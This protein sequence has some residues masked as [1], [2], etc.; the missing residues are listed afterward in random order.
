MKVIPLDF[1]GG[2]ADGGSPEITCEVRRSRRKTLAV[3]VHHGRIEVR[4]PY[5]TSQ[6]EI[7]RFLDQHRQ[8]IAERLQQESE[9]ERE[10]LRIEPGRI[11][12]Y[13]ARELTLCFEEH[14]VRDIRIEAR[15]FVICGP[16][17]TTARARAQLEAFLIRQAKA[18]LPERARALATH[19]GVGDKLKSVKLRKTKSK[20]GHC[21]SNG[22]IQF[23]W[24]IMLAPPA[25][26]DYM[27]AH[28]VCHL[29]HMNH[30]RRF[31]QLVESVCPDS[32]HYIDW[33]K[34]HEH[35]YWIR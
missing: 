34:A 11:L 23:N 10:A 31:W 14:P 3:H 13:Q 26:I 12:F 35:R 9:R 5:F 6:R 28:E 33:L 22:I 1:G 18:C 21:T 4:A 25:I 2:P 24:L 17:L 19:L 7:A 20:W 8:W 16:S 32:R 29:V 15:R 30:S 27:I